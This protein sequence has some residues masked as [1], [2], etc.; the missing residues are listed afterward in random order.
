MEKLKIVLTTYSESC[1]MITTRE[2][3]DEEGKRVKPMHTVTNLSRKDGIYFLQPGTYY[4]VRKEQRDRE[5]EERWFRICI[6]PEGGELK[7]EIVEMR[8]NPFT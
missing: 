2:M 4:Y 6:K 7:G 5:I 3:Y 8:E 1:E